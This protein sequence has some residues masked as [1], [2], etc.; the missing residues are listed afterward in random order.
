MVGLKIT[1]QVEKVDG[2]EISYI[3]FAE[4]YMNTNQPVVLTGLMDDWRA[5]KDWVFPDGSPN[6]SF[7]S[8]SFGNSRVQVF[9]VFTAFVAKISKIYLV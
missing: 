4:K 1:G 8:S 5:C 7:L 2:K 6:L 9:F 3:E